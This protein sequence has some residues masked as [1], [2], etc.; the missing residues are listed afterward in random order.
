MATR[1]NIK[2]PRKKL[3]D[4][5]EKVAYA[6]AGE[7]YQEHPH[8]LRKVSDSF[9]EVAFAE[10]GEDLTDAITLDLNTQDSLELRKPQYDQLARGHRLADRI[11]Y[12]RG[13]FPARKIQDQLAAATAG[14]IDPV[15]IHA[16]LE[17][18]RRRT[19]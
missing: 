1:K 7:L 2:K 19:V 17:S 10:S 4:E 3:T 16:A 11:D 14:P 5:F 15:R 8:K 12:S 6:E 13:Q 9:A 18:V